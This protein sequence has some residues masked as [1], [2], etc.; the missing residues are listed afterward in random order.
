VQLVDIHG[1]EQRGS[2]LADI[3]PRLPRLGGGKEV[4]AHRGEVACLDH[5]GHQHRTDHP[6]PTYKTYIFH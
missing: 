3:R 5:A 4:G 1:I 6:A 2:A